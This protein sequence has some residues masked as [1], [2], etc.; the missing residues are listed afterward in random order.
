VVLGCPTGQVNVSPL[1]LAMDLSRL[2]IPPHPSGNALTRLPPLFPLLFPQ[3]PNPPL[4]RHSPHFPAQSPCP[5]IRH[6]L[7]L[8]LPARFLASFSH[9]TTISLPPPP[10]TP[11]NRTRALSPPQAYYRHPTTLFSSPYPTSFFYSHRGPS[12]IPHHPFPT[13]TYHPSHRTGLSVRTL[14]RHVAS[15]ESGHTGLENFRF[16]AAA[17]APEDWAGEAAHRVACRTTRN[18]A[19]IA[20][21]P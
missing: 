8:S 16:A 4:F 15:P 1:T 19:L 20:G 5:P 11:F 9:S 17:G 14:R 13:T 2:L 7:V 3:S 12:T 6:C 18:D 10:Q 21:T